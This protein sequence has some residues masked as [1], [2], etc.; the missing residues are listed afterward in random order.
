MLVQHT[1][2]CFLCKKKILKIVKII[3]IGPKSSRKIFR[4]HKRSKT[5]NW[6]NCHKSIL[7]VTTHN[8]Q[9]YIY[10][11]LVCL[12]QNSVTVNVWKIQPDKVNFESFSCHNFSALTLI[13]LIMLSLHRVWPS[14]CKSDR[15][16]AF[17]VCC[18]PKWRLR[19][20][21]LCAFR[22]ISRRWQIPWKS[23]NICSLKH[24]FFNFVF[25]SFSYFLSLIHRYV[26]LMGIQERN[27]RLFY[28][29]LME[30][31][32]E[33]MPIVYTPTVGLACT[34]YGHIFRRPK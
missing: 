24:L 19:T 11:T 22:G 7:T 13:I 32:E 9:K 16:W 27:E 10:G 14:P 6:W 5:Q 23:N 4:K 29:V 28:R 21:R 31:I 30:D 18:L 26:Y 34:Q 12:L 33:L 3:S 2:Y 1:V 15:F 25:F 17:M 20:F 8:L